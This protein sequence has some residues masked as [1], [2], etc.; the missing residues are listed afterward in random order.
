MPLCPVFLLRSSRSFPSQQ[1][2]VSST[3]LWRSQE[4]GLLSSLANVIG[5]SSKKPSSTRVL[6]LNSLLGGSAISGLTNAVGRYA[7]IGE[8]D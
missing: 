8:G 5:G 6:T 3:M 1:A 7:G 4:P 2:Q